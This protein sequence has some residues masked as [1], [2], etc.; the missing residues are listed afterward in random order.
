M[1]S[2]EDVLFLDLIEEHRIGRYLVDS[3]LAIAATIIVT[4]IIYAGS[5]YPRIPNISF[6][7]LLVVLGLAT[8]RGLYAAVIASLIAFL[9][10]D[11]FL[12]Q[13]LY[14]FTVNSPEEWLA[15]CIFL[16][17]AIIT[18]Q[19]AAALRQRAEQAMLRERETRV[20][21]ELVNAT[22]SEE[23]LEKQLDIVANAITSNFALE[24]IHDC[25]ILLP[26]IHGRLML[27][28]DVPRPVEQ[29][30]LSSDEEKT[31][32]SVMLQ[33]RI[34][35]VYAGSNSN[36][37]QREGSNH[38]RRIFSIKGREE[39]NHIRL[40]PLQQGQ[41]VVGVARLVMNSG[42]AKRFPGERN[43]EGQ[44][45]S[46]NHHSAFFWTFLDQATAMIER[47]RVHRDALQIELLRRTDALRSAL[48]SSVSH[49]LRTPL[50][51]IKAAA[52]SLL[53]EDVE[54]DE[55]A[56]RSFASA[57]EREADRLN[58][59]V[60]NLL[61][62]SRIEGGALKAEKEWYL[63]KELIQD[64][65]GHMY[66]VLQDREVSE[67]I[68]DAL[69]PVELDYLQ[70]DQVLTN[71]IENVVRYTPPASPI[72]IS[73]RVTES[74][75]I[76]SI[77][78]RGPGIPQYDLERIFDKFYRV[79]GAKRRNSSVMGTGLGLAVCRGL[80][81]AHGGRIWAENRSGGGA[82]FRFTL[83]LKEAEG[84]MHE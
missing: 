83:P 62:M 13:P 70:I 60:G 79:S 47:A 76:V 69:P 56:K 57:I 36:V 15:L 5:L 31:A 45:V 78:D 12:V 38:F 17:T 34:V 42:T 46:L 80:V 40:I 6:L 16:I 84:H 20:L 23:R 22:T 67:D 32:Q 18:G 19:L 24:G 25:A 64:V 73:A 9:S 50:A 58:R 51:S 41:S 4:G 72:E 68:P 39:Q 11:Y 49:D 21:Y 48:L 8:R 28:T 44:K 53:Q 35:D 2:I 7:Y 3:L 82:I 81:E 52:S 77:A 26:D 43:V 75:L 29:I 14:T 27:Q 33:G 30:Q 55:E 37:M 66:T 71:L 54:W 59:L 61:D 65:L 74:Q 10:F 1:K 63:V